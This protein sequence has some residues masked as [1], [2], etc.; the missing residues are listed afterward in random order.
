MATALRDLPGIDRLLQSERL[1][2]CVRTHGEL[3]VK[4]TLRELQSGWR[5]EGNAPDWAADPAAYAAEVHARLARAAYTPVFNLTGTVLHTN[6]GRALV[7][8]ALYRSVEPLVTRPMN[9]EYDLA[10]G[11]R[12]NRE[13]FVEDR[14]TLLTGAEA[15]TVV[16]NGAAALML[17]LNTL[18]LDRAVP[19][20]RGELIEIGGSFRLPDIM[21]RSGCRLAEVGTT[22]RTH[23]RDFEAAI[24]PDTGMLLKVHPSNYHI[25]GFTREVGVSEL[26]AL[27]HAH[28]L[29]LA[30]DLGSGTLVDLARYGLPHEPM[31]QEVL[32][33]GADLVTFSGDKL[34]GATQAGIVVGRRD[35]VDAL[36]QNP[37]KRALRPDKLTLAF[38][39]RTLAL[40]EDPDR[41]PET[42][43][44]LATL[45][46][47]LGT[48]TSRAERIRDA[49][50]ANLPAFTVA[51][52][53]S[54]CQIGS[55][56]LPAQRLPGVA[57]TLHH[58]DG[59]RVRTLLGRLRDL[60]VPVIG[61]LHQGRIWLD[62]RGAERLDELVANLG[63]L[64][65]AS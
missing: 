10:S 11:R 54:E 26:A 21:T 56:S 43:P 25:G 48:L 60:P 52:E 20:S 5:S 37:M 64:V 49:L 61:R 38:L 28:D 47:D 9:L 63:S 13:Q 3:R 34:L 53:E 16:N 55:G 29:P 22:N 6:L 4:A 24:G 18:A 51:I 46:T 15:A 27:A 36:K 8:E 7:S 39:E 57:V 32:S 2:A 17:V 35:L 45:T 62:T 44:L 40:Y 41:L 59:A 31:P 1:A 58:D 19:V 65:D 23:L 50:T 33:Q 42:L 30:V 14:L 12:G